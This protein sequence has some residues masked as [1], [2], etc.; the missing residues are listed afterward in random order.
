MK[1]SLSY[2]GL[3]THNGVERLFTHYCGK[4][5]KFLR[6]Y[7]PDL[8]QCH[9]AVEFSRKKNH[10]GLSLN[11]TLPTATL[12]AVASAKDVHSTVQEAFT[13]LQCQLKKH[14]EKLR[15]E[16]EWKRKRARGPLALSKA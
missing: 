11:M 15:H 16:H 1:I 12:H 4:M 3:S 13:E 2:R 6:A 8:V 10:Y 7:N 14:K 9:G 5:E